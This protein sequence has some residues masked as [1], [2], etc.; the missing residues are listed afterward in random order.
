V[1]FETVTE[2]L[3]SFF[4]SAKFPMCADLW[5]SLR[6]LRVLHR[7]KTPLRHVVSNKEI[8]V[9]VERQARRCF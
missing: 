9:R 1:A 6:R 3:A 4:P 8:A 7:P 2:K 5:R